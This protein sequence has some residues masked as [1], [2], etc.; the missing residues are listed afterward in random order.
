VS[1]LSGGEKSRLNLAK[2]LI[3]PPN[4]LLL[5]EPTTHLDVD[6]VDAL[7]RALTMYEGTIVFI[8]HDI[9]FVRSVANVVYE[10][11]EGHVRKFHGNFDYYLEKKK[12]AEVILKSQRPVIEKKA[13]SAQ[14]AERQKAR[15]DQRKS[16][17]DER[18][19]KVHN[20]SLGVKIQKL[21]KEKEE[22]QLESYAKA[23][24]L[25]D[26]KIYRDENV[27]RD[28]GRRLKEIEKRSGEIDEEIKRLQARML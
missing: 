3:N 19:R 13:I 1:V 12:E 17:V 14:E 18:Q 8:S 16:Q 20:S 5:D 10:V 6:A 2:F 22:L 25:S 15:D 28:Y 26:Q 24:A 11:I 4:F 9:H 23:R 7:I 21:Q 27:V